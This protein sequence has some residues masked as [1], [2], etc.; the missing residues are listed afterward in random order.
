MYV[1]ALCIYTSIHACTYYVPTHGHAVMRTR[2]HV[3]ACIHAYACVHTCMTYTIFCDLSRWE[4]PGER[5]PRGGFKISHLEDARLHPFAR[6][7]G[8]GGSPMGG[9]GWYRGGS[10][11]NTT[12]TT[13]TTNNT[14][15]NN[16]NSNELI[17]IIMIVARSR[18]ADFE[19]P[20]PETVF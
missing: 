5:K 15:D 1:Y 3:Y 19:L 10:R 11:A 13:T 17:I 2:V 6:P 8:G 12:T 9:R 16:N 4:A 20:G 7:G 18:Q 14:T